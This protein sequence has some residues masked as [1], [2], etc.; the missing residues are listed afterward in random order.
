M[1]SQI[2]IAADFYEKI[3]EKPPVRH[4]V[5]TPYAD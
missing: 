3:T 4:G 1:R 2:C 5:N